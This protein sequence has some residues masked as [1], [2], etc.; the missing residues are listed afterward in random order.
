MIRAAGVS[1]S[2]ANR[3]VFRAPLR[4][5][6]SAVQ[7]PETGGETRSVT[8]RQAAPVRLP[9]E[10]SLI[11]NGKLHYLSHSDS[12]QSHVVVG[13]NR[14][15]VAFPA[16]NSGL[17]LWLDPTVAI[18]SLGPPV[19]LQVPDGQGVSLPFRSDSGRMVI[20]DTILDSI[21]TIRNRSK[22][23]D[24]IEQMRN[25]R[26]GFARRFGAEPSWVNQG[27]HL[28]VKGGKTRL[29]IERRELD[30]K[31]YRL[32]FVL[33]P[34]VE[35][36]HQDQP[37]QSSK[38]IFTAPGKF[39]FSL[40]ASVPFLPLKGYVPEELFRP[41]ALGLLQQLQSAGDPRA[42]RFQDAMRDLL[43]LAREDKFMAGSWQY[44][45]Y[46]GRDTLLSL[47]LLDPVVTTKAYSNGILSVFNRMRSDGK[48]A[49]EESLGDWAESTQL[50]QLKLSGAASA[51]PAGMPQLSK[52]LL[53]SLARQLGK[54]QYDY[55]MQDDDFLLTL[56]TERLVSDPETAGDFLASTTQDGQTG[57]DKVLQNWSYVLRKSVELARDSASGAPR[58]LLHR[59][60][61][62][63][64]DGED[65]GNWRDSQCGLGWG[66]YPADIN[67]VLLPAALRAIARMAGRIPAQFIEAEAALKGL[68]DLPQEL[69][70]ASRMAE[71][72]ESVRD[73]F[74]VELGPEQIRERLGRFFAGAA[75]T[76]EEKQLYR[77]RPVGRGG[78]TLGEFLDG[79]VVPEALKD[80][81][82]FLALS[83]DQNGKKVE[84]L[85]S[86]FSFD[87]F[88]GDPSRKEVEDAL[89]LLELEYPLGL[90]TGVGPVVANPAY[91]QDP[92]H[93]AELSRTAYHG[94]LVWT[95]Q[96]AMIKAGLIRQLD[97]FSNEPDLCQRI[98]EAIQSLN[99]A[100]IKA[101]PLATAELYTHDVSAGEWKAVPFGGPN[102]TDKTEANPAQ[103]WSTVYPA[104]EMRAI[105]H[106]IDV[107]AK[108]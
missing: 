7:E 5:A 74:R 58:E 107:P 11:E 81:L 54:P 29:T 86:D 65:V 42:Q 85:N 1:Y 16:Q 64:Q 89:K 73:R 45:T 62:R 53:D 90:M 44:M 33:P 3:T 98:R 31:P 95:W 23:T 70:E 72:W 78:P 94:S 6:Q 28:S 96:T 55:K 47:M 48:V 49:H 4:S 60:M 75:L 69:Q 14:L 100:E 43:F 68:P 61:V 99:A 101:G 38:W 56:A 15:V 20:D 34:E 92:R 51:A 9:T 30:G 32:T 102:S 103:L 8:R 84:V 50:Q 26:E 39:D 40:E 59:N 80:G 66:K 12:E 79:Q 76:D 108:P 13:M 18:A 52:A 19:P 37:D 63:L 82:R 35:L 57:F 21:R 83:L 88:L 93:A 46:F 41:Q 10:H 77:S 97:R 91:S 67:C 25:Q 106:G 71:E 27:L 87:L 22:I 2:S 17:S 104:V 105:E 24:E 36:E